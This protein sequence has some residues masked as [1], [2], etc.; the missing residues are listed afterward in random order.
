MACVRYVSIDYVKVGCVTNAKP[1]GQELHVVFNYKE[2]EAKF[3]LV[4]VLAHAS[5]TGLLES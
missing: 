2:V 1:E 3:G 4:S 5:Q